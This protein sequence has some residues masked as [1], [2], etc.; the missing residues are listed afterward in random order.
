MS[1]SIALYPLQALLFFTSPFVL[2][3]GFVWALQPKATVFPGPITVLRAL[4]RSD[5]P[6]LGQAL[7]ES[8]AVLAWALPVAVLAGVGLALL[9]ALF[10]GVGAFV[11]PALVG[12]FALPVYAVNR[13]L[14]SLVSLG[15]ASKVTVASLILYFPV[16]IA[17]LVG[18]R[19]LDPTLLEAAKLD[20][21]GR[22]QILLLIMLPLAGPALAGGLLAAGAVAPLALFAGEQTGPASG[23]GQLI[24]R[25][26]GL[27]VNLAFAGVA[28]L[29]LI[30]LG[31]FALADAARRWLTRH[32]PDS[33]LLLRKA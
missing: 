20:G 10:R 2:W 19:S 30:G 18:L 3:Q 29:I 6:R 22:G 32:S 16:L 33:F 8:L 15:F 7:A 14:F 17:A 12:L 11:L 24:R 13:A 25:E 9:M 26:F 27:D 4:E 1:P 21:A 28:L 31:L 5:M 23:L